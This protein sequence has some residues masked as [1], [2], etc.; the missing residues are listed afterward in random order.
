MRGTIVILVLCGIVPWMALRSV[1]GAQHSPA[2]APQGASISNATAEKILTYIR[3]RF[4]VPPTVKLSLGP[5]QTSPIAPDFYEGVVIVDDGKNQHPQ[6]TMISKDSRYLIVVSGGVLNLQQNTPAEM[7]Q[8]IRVAFKTEPT[9]KLTVGG[10]RRSP[11]ADFEEGTL[12]MGEGNAKQDRTLLVTRDGK[13]LIVSDLY[14]L[15]IDPRQ[16]ALHTISL[17]GEPSQ[18]PANAPVTI[19]EYA[20]LECPTCARM[21]AFLETQVVPRYGNKIR[22]IF[23]EYPLPMHDWSLTAAI[24]CQ[25]AYE[26]NPAAY[27]PMRTAIFQN[28][29]L[30]NITNVRETVLSYGEQAGVDRVKLAGCLDAKSSYPRIQRDVAEAKRI[31]VNQTPTVFIN[32]RMM[33]GLPSEEAYFQAIDEALREA[34]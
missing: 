27:V 28:Q 12:S 3:E 7:E 11:V 34:K 29:Q 23:K 5:F 16:Q 31:D 25:C 14:S 22:V 32:G 6:P 17:V 10:F 9:L 19:V 30:I 21:Q 2:P 15:A 24:G 1:A 4:G 18:G 33:V 20:D 26:L 8:R 13:H